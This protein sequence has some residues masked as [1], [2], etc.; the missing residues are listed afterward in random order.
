MPL[1]IPESLAWAHP[2]TAEWFLPKNLDTLPWGDSSKL[3][4]KRSM[5]TRF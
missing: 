4:S 5:K 3:K 1:E 2:V